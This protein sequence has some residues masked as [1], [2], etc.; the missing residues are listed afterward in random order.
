MLKV[1]L[2]TNHLSNNIIGGSQGGWLIQ[3]GMWNLRKYRE[4]YGEQRA[5]K[6]TIHTVF[7]LNLLFEFLQQTDPQHSSE[8][9]K[10]ISSGGL[11]F[12]C[13]SFHEG[14][15]YLKAFDKMVETK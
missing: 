13:M 6:E 1:Y 11:R 7:F 14:A 5:T 15:A 2:N 9:L 4:L 3:V 10:V 8:I 12:F